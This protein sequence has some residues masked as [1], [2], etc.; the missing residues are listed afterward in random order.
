MVRMLKHL[1]DRFLI[2]FFTI[3]FLIL[4]GCSVTSAIQGNIGTTNG[5]APQTQIQNSSAISLS[6]GA[7]QATTSQGS[8]G[9]LT[10]GKPVLGGHLQTSGGYQVTFSFQGSAQ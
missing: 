2:V 5:S 7:V 1:L 3:Q 9:Q 4:T 6:S 8:T 10:L